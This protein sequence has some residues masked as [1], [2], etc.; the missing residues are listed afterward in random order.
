[1]QQITCTPLWFSTLLKDVLIVPIRMS[2]VP[3]DIML[4]DLMHLILWVLNLSSFVN[5]FTYS[6]GVKPLLVVG[7]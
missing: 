3:L 6:W 1:M 5:A 7:Q 4:S 2:F